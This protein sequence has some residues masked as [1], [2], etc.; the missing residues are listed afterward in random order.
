M[1]RAAN[2]R[3]RGIGSIQ[4]M[5]AVAHCQEVQQKANCSS[6]PRPQID[7]ETRTSR[8]SQQRILTGPKVRLSNKQLHETHTRV[9]H[10]SGVNLPFPAVP[11]RL[12]AESLASRADQN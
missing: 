3:L 1:D 6:S 11:A 10:P 12:L 8:Q 4:A 9:V 7:P 2:S 5:L